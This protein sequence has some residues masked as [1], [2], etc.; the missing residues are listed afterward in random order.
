MPKIN[1]ILCIGNNTKETNSL[2]KTLAIPLALEYR[3]LIDNV[4]IDPITGV[5]HTSIEDLSIDNIIKII[6]KFDQVQVFV[7]ANSEDRA[8]YQ[9]RLILKNQIEM[10]DTNY[11]FHDEKMLF[12]GCSHTAGIGHKSMDTVYPTLVAKYLNKDPLI[13]GNSGKGNYLLEHV[14]NLYSLKDSNV[15]IQFTDIFRLR[16]Y[17]SAGKIIEKQASGYTMEEANMYTEEKLVKDFLEL[18]NR[19]VIR[20]RDA[21]ANFVFFQLT[22]HHPTDLQIHY[23]LSK[24]KEFCWLPDSRQDNADDDLH[25][26]IKSHK[27][28]ADRLIQRWNVLYAQN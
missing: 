19:V 16:Y 18:V 4:N 22:H 10:T 8:A 26:G 5:Y 2:A 21:N 23:E 15:V 24:Y 3:G 17:N 20:L 11:R 12:V 7:Q 28:I 13:L 9:Q 1:K 14:L 25:F 27:L 6:N